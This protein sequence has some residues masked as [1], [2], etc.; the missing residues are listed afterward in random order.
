MISTKQILE[1]VSDAM[2]IP[3]D[4]DFSLCKDSFQKISFKEGDEIALF[5]AAQAIMT[6][7]LNVKPKNN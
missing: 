2:S 3:W 5:V 4:D 1:F 7:Q 6:P